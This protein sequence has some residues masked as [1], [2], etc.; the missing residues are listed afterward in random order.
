MLAMGVLNYVRDNVQVSH[1]GF[2]DILLDFIYKQGTSFGVLARGFLFNSSLPYRD[3][4]N[5]TFGPVLDY[6]ARG[7][8]GAIFGGKAFEHTTNSVELAIDSNSYAHN[9]SYLVLNKEYLKGHG[10][11]S[12]YIMELYTDYGMIG[13]FLLSLLLGMLFI[14][15]LQVAYRSRTILFALSLLILNNL[16]FMPRSSFSESFFNLFTMQFWG[17]VLVI[18]FVAKMLTKENQYLLNKGEKNH[19]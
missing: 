3:F 7:S 9:L 16:F 6:F 11:G 19:V 4:R 14:A 17:I 10:I 12:S 2:W 5:F 1:T 13:V 15:M 18:I 8:L